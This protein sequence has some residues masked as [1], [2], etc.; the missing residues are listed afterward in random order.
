MAGHGGLGVKG[1]SGVTTLLFTDIEG[2]TRLWEQEG[3]RMSRAL[4]AHDSLSRTAVEGNHGI[5]LKMTGDGMYAAFDD[6]LEALNATVTLQQALGDPNQTHGI[7][8][9]V[10]AGLHLG[11][12]ERR[13]NDI[14]GSPVNRAARIM[15]AA[16]GGQILLSQALVDRVRGHLPMSA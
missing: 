15:K 16:H 8:F 14:F 11:I 4:A 13:D 12:V 7:S 3:E 2:S 6:P 9:R 1:S 5:V 10:R